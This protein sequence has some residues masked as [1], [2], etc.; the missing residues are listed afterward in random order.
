LIADKDPSKSFF[1][2]ENQRLMRSITRL[3]MEKIFRKRA[4]EKNDVEYK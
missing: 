1:N 2:A 3:Q 4:V